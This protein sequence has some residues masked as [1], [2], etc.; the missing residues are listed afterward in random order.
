MQAQQPAQGVVQANDEDWDEAEEEEEEEEQ[1]E[2]AQQETAVAVTAKQQQQQQQHQQHKEREEAVK[3]DPQEQLRD[4]SLD[5]ADY[6]PRHRFRNVFELDDR[7]SLLRAN[8]VS[9]QR[10]RWP[11]ILKQAKSDLAAQRL[12]AAISELEARHL[13]IADDDIQLQR[14]MELANMS[15]DFR[16]KLRAVNINQA[17]FATQNVALAAFRTGLADFVAEHDAIVR[18]HLFEKRSVEQRLERAAVMVQCETALP[19][20]IYEPEQLAR[21]RVLSSMQR[22][23]SIIRKKEEVQAAGLV[24]TRAAV[25]L[26]EE[27]ARTAMGVL[28]RQEEARGRRDVLQRELCQIEKQARAA[29]EDTEKT[30]E[31]ATLA[32]QQRAEFEPL[33]AALFVAAFARL[34]REAVAALNLQINKEDDADRA[35]IATQFNKHAVHTLASQHR[36]ERGELEAEEQKQRAPIEDADET[37]DRE[38]VHSRRAAA[39]QVM[40]QRLHAERLAQAIAQAKAAFERELFVLEEKACNPSALRAPIVAEEAKAR[41][42]IALARRAGAANILSKEHEAARRVLEGTE[43]E[44]RA[45]FVTAQADAADEKLQGASTALARMAREQRRHQEQLIEE[46]QTQCSRIQQ[47]EGEAHISLSTRSQQLYE[48]VLSN[49]FEAVRRRAEISMGALL[50]REAA[51]RSNVV[52][53]EEHER[54]ER[55]ECPACRVNPPYRLSRLAA[56]INESP[57]G[58]GSKKLRQHLHHHQI[59]IQKMRIQRQAL[60]TEQYCS[61][62]VIE[63]S[64]FSQYMLEVYGALSTLHLAVARQRCDDIASSTTVAGSLAHIRKRERA[65]WL[66]RL[67]VCL[68]AEQRA[69]LELQHMAVRGT[70]EIRAMNALLVYQ[71][72]DVDSTERA[73]LLANMRDAFPLQTLFMARKRQQKP[74]LEDGRNYVDEKLPRRRVTMSIIARNAQSD[75]EECFE[76]VADHVVSSSGPL[77]PRLVSSSL[78]DDDAAAALALGRVEMLERT[79][80]ALLAAKEGRAPS[81]LRNN[82]HSSSSLS[83]PTTTTGAGGGG[84]G[85]GGSGATGSIGASPFVRHHSF[86]AANA[87]NNSNQNKQLQMARSAAH[88]RGAQ[89]LD[90]LHADSPHDDDDNADHYNAAEREL[91]LS[92]EK[93]ASKFAQEEQQQQQQ[94]QQSSVSRN[95]QQQQQHALLSRQTRSR[96]AIV[97]QTELQYRDKIA[98]TES[99]RRA[100]MAASRAMG[101][102]IVGLS[103]QLEEAIARLRFIEAARRQGL[104]DAEISDRAALYGSRRGSRLK[105]PPRIGGDYAAETRTTH[106]SPSGVRIVSVD[107]SPHG[108]QRQR[109]EPEERLS[110]IAATTAQ[111]SDDE[112]FKQFKV[113]RRMQRYNNNAV[114]AARGDESAAAAGTSVVATDSAG[115]FDELH[116]LASASFADGS[117][118]ASAAGP[119]FAS[120]PVLAIRA[121]EAARAVASAVKS[122]QF[123]GVALDREMYS[124]LKNEQQLVE[125]QV[126]VAQWK[127]GLEEKRR[128]LETALNHHPHQPGS[129][130]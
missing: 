27:S 33:F 100:R 93:E 43:A 42:A 11:K 122:K 53:R 86:A 85:G 62:G 29:L 113:Q 116:R 119:A 70:I 74:L 65:E 39:L 35:L 31:R 87:H 4:F 112:D 25:E 125:M 15:S 84:G 3:Q 32:D 49:F 102:A 117:A 19:G 78:E 47:Q 21:V 64:A 89:L 127:T 7:E 40:K 56:D 124:V 46:Q 99:D 114:A 34:E 105:R 55:W 30:G 95:Q 58:M 22:A 10:T 108:Q 126:H 69:R 6:N 111:S 118:A 57:N 88:S 83:S 106:V 101:V 28:F 120:I 63:A 81:P 123:S 9:V 60:I 12:R 13:R 66:A 80:D 107:R 96:L 109:S 103:P 82:T 115:G 92:L 98:T 72:T 59:E 50:K 110:R 94:Q 48:T 128:Q 37:T 130:F 44:T 75:D 121:R 104:C 41:G 67:E 5:P 91:Q 14:N 54:D 129:R 18:R 73:P 79:V 36:R 51:E 1:E 24:T 76:P 38:N 26:D 90:S 16:K 45:V 23:I 68:F 20:A 61:R 2:E 71:T 17:L 52:A 8:A 97:E 77:P